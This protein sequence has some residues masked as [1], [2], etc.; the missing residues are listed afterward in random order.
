MIVYNTTYRVDAGADAQFLS[1]VRES[2]IPMSVRSGELTEPRLCRVE[3]DDEK[4]EGRSYSLQ[5][6]VKSREILQR[7]YEEEGVRSSEEMTARFGNSV[8][9]F[10]TLLTVMDI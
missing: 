3:T 4:E 6:T 5:F 1:W 9:G 7:W 10:V 8:L 2:L